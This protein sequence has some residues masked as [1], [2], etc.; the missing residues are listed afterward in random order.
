MEDLNL[1]KEAVELAKIRGNVRGVVFQTHAS[2][3]RQREGDAGLVNVEKKM[4]E[5]GQPIKFRDI[6]PFSWNRTASSVLVILVAKKLFNWT[7]KDIFEMGNSAPKYSFTVKMLMKYFL[8]SEKTF[9]ESPKYWEKH[10]DTGKIEPFK[11]SAVE[12]IYV[13]RLHDFKINPVLCEYFRGYFIRIGQLTQKGKITGEQ[14]KCVFKGDPYCEYIIR[15][16]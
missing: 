3:I 14:V 16:E 5:L 15:W 9:E 13:L 7:D 11:Y 1:E 8:S 10:Y 2:Y 6:K 4:E 12:K